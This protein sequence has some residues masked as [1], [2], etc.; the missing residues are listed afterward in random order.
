M[1][2]TGHTPYHLNAYFNP[3]LHAV[4]VIRSYFCDYLT[5]M[6]VRRRYNMLVITRT[7]SPLT[8]LDI[9]FQQTA[10]RITSTTTD[11]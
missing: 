11:S 4:N 1:L 8:H 2:L 6:S 3:P 7:L 5:T 10:V 9:I